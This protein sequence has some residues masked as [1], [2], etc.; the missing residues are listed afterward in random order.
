MIRLNLS[1]GSADTRLARMLIGQ[2][3]SNKS[4]G[5]VPEEP[6][7][8]NPNRSNVPAGSSISG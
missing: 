4:A 6:L 5:P 3:L 7:R 8:L 1:A 2:Y